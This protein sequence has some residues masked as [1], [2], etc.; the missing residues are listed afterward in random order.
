MY[1]IIYIFDVIRDNSP[2]FEKTPNAI[3]IRIKPTELRYEFAKNFRKLCCKIRVYE[4][5][6]IDPKPEYISTIS[7]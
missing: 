5:T 3:A 1:T 2:I 6:A 7:T 4:L